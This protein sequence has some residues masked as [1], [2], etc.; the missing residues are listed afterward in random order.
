MT[1]KF[2]MK[3]FLP[4]GTNRSLIDKLKLEPG[5]IVEIRWTDVWTTDR[6][7]WGEVNEIKEL[8][9]TRT[10]GVVLRQME[11]GLLIALEIGDRYGDGHTVQQMPYGLIQCVTILGKTD[12]PPE[13]GP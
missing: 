13:A 5:D 11:T 8:E 9:Q 7:T 10:Y 12:L 6:V 1:G 3:L 4:A 2:P